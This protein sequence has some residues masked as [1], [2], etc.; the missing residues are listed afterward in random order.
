MKSTPPTG[1]RMADDPHNVEKYEELYRLTREGIEQEKAR[2]NRLDEK[3]SRYLSFLGI[4]AGIGAFAVPALVQTLRP[5][6]GF[7]DWAA[8][9]SSVLLFWAVF[10]AAMVTFSV[11]KLQTW[12]VFPMD[13]ELLSYFRENRYV[14]ILYSLARENIRTVN[15]NRHSITDRQ[16]ITLKW[17]YRFVIVALV[18]SVSATITSTI[19]LMLTPK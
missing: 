7:W 8:I 9:A 18:L 12:V 19:A 4:V 17:A 2:S 15:A 5:V 1:K 6:E 14:N 10:V 3:A 16:A 11:L 13:D